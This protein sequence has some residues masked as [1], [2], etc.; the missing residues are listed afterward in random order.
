MND[1]IHRERTFGTSNSEEGVGG[2]KMKELSSDIQDTTNEL[3]TEKDSDEE[4][5]GVEDDR[6]G[7][8]RDENENEADDDNDGHSAKSKNNPL[9]PKQRY[10]TPKI[11]RDAITVFI[12]LDVTADLNIAIKH[13]RAKRISSIYKRFPSLQKEAKKLDEKNSMK[14]D[15]DPMIDDDEED[16]AKEKEDKQLLKK[17]KKLH[18]EGLRT[19]ENMSISDSDEES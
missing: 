6:D 17:R 16:N 8:E 10:H 4:M 2:D 12:P 1:E 15:D 19:F 18:E 11:F 5:S 14:D 13:T 7:A 3:T 9:K